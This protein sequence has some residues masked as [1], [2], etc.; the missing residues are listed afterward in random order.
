[1]DWASGV[2][3]QNCALAKQP[4]FKPPPVCPPPRRNVS[5][6]EATRLG[7][8]FAPILYQHP[9]DNSWLTDPP[10]YL[11]KTRKYDTRSWRLVN[12]TKVLEGDDSEGDGPGN[13]TTSIVEYLM[14]MEYL[15]TMYVNATRNESTGEVSFEVDDGPTIERKAVI[16]PVVDGKLT[17]KVYYTVFRPRDPSTGA[18]VPHA[19]VYTYNYYYPWNGCSNQLVATQVDGRFQAV[20]YAMCPDGW[21]EGD[22]EHLKVWVCEDD[23]YAEDPASAIRRAQYSQ[24]GWLP[25]FD[26]DAGECRYETD[27]KGVRRLVTM[28][29]LYAHAN[30]HEETPLFVYAKVRLSFLL[31]MDGVY[32][33][34]RYKKGPVLYPDENNTLFLPFLNEMTLDQMRNEYAWA[35]FP[36]IWGATIT[37]SSP[38]VLTCFGNNISSRVP[39]TTLNPAYYMLDL[40]V[41]PMGSD[42]TAMNFTA[43][44]EGN[45]VTGPLWRRAFTHMWE[46][47]RPS[48]LWEEFRFGPIRMTFDG[49]CPFAG[50]IVTT[51][52]GIRGFHHTNL[53]NFLGAITGLILASSIV[54]FAMV[55][56]IMMVRG[57][58]AAEDN[59][60]TELLDEVLRKTADK[61]ASA[62][63]MSKRQPALEAHAAAGDHAGGGGGEP[64]GPT[65][66][67]AGAGVSPTLNYMRVS[68]KLILH[69]FNASVVQPYLLV[70]W[71]CV[72]LA[73]YICGVVLGAIGIA[74]VTTALNRVVPNSIWTTINNAIIAVFVIFGFVGLLVVFT[75]LFIRP[76]ASGLC[77]CC[78]PAAPTL[79]SMR[80]SW[81]AHAVLAGLLTIEMNVTM[82]LFAFGMVLWVA[83]YGVE[84]VCNNAVA[85]LFS[86]VS[87]SPDVCIDLSNIGLRKLGNNGTMCGADLVNLCAM[88]SDLHVD[89][90]E[91]GAML[92]LMAQAMFLVLASTSYVAM[93]AGAAITA[94]MA[95][96]EEEER[97]RVQGAS[98]ASKSWLSWGPLK[99][100]SR[101]PSELH[102][103]EGK[104]S[105]NGGKGGGKGGSKG[106]LHASAP[107]MVGA[108]IAPA[109][110][111]GSGSDSPGQ[112]GADRV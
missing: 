78:G 34:D 4:A 9:L 33:A 65:S 40:F 11:E 98:G 71:I 74:D 37:T 105:E 77:R 89:F 62:R 52:A 16:D 100:R 56:P 55:L 58:S 29:G 68:H 95:E 24:H 8:R 94:A 42:W 103:A 38:R 1:M 3:G 30:Y 19:Y 57:N 76:T 80:S 86:K 48:P 53:A 97:E 112:A 88:W 107:A 45:T 83:R 66:E 18:A 110:E 108:T 35:V 91:Y 79:E 27:P 61:K 7:V 75:A 93:R 92:L 14:N 96:I 102:G 25:D 49:L 47:E 39:C 10:R 72:G 70:V 109:G 36:G 32:I 6:R 84:Q 63:A 90:L 43:A 81:R 85:L 69:A 22:L 41:R 17:G 5:R 82:L 60:Y 31:N 99:R 64:G 20:E 87:F 67:G 50:P 104:G 54:C 26:C 13:T 59:V 2:A 73:C 21:H 44:A 23:L 101:V 51:D 28:A 15:A 46:M 12:M 106:E 111:G